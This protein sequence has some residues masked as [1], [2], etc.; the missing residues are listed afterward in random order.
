TLSTAYIYDNNGNL[1]SETADAAATTYTWDAD[2]RLRQVTQPRALHSYEYDAHGLRT[3]KVEAGVETRFLLDGPSVL[4]EYDSTNVAAR[5]YLHSPESIDDIYE[6]AEGG[7]LYFP[8]K[9]ALGSV[10][11]LTDSV[12]AVVRRNSYEV[13]GARTSTGT[14]PD[15][16]FGFT[17][18]EQDSGGLNYNRNRF[19]MSRTGNW[20]QAD[21]SGMIDGPSLYQYV[22]ANPVAMK[23]PTGRFSYGSGAPPKSSWRPFSDFYENIGDADVRVER[24]V[25]IA[26]FLRIAAKPACGSAFLKSC[27]ATPT[28]DRMSVAVELSAHTVI[29][30]IDNSARI[31]AGGTIADGEAAKPLG[32]RPYQIALAP[33]VVSAETSTV[34]ETASKIIHEWAHHWL[35]T[36]HAPSMPNGSA[37]DPVYEVQRSCE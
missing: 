37:N 28:R 19:Y 21:R 26:A 10:V 24:A 5:R 23:D 29:W 12:G 6:F 33:G 8:L 27:S 32:D 4:A 25:F 7:Q 11:A 35:R 18:R 17:G 14:G 20:L 36:S 3:K 30:G 2:N 34:N 22:K 9:D 31:A 15:L 13:Y 16:A 1:T